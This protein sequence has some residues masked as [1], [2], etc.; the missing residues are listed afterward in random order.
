MDSQQI[1]TQLRPILEQIRKETFKPD[2]Q[3]KATDEQLI[4]IMVSKF[5]EWGGN[6]IIQ[7]ALYSLEDSNFHG[8]VREISKVT[9]IKI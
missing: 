2:Y 7:A 8:E 4:G 9:G 5:F 1:Q 6:E 3:D